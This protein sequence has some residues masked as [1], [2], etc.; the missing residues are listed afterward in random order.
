MNAVLRQIHWFLIIWRIHSDNRRN[1][2][3]ADQHVS[4]KFGEN[5]QIQIVIKQ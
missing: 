2:P 5:G 4:A 1:A 3:K